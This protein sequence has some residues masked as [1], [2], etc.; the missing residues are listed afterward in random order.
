MACLVIYSIAIKYVLNWSSKLN[1]YDK[2]RV[3]TEYIFKHDR[4]YYVRIILFLIFSVIV[5]HV[6]L[7][8]TYMLP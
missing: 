5:K 2:E 7:L 3:I 4:Q 8:N 6:T 1:R